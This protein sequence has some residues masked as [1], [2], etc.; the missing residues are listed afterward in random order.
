MARKKEKEDKKGKGFPFRRPPSLEGF[1]KTSQR[2]A[3]G[4]GVSADEKR[5]LT[6]EEFAEKYPSTATLPSDTVGAPLFSILRPGDK[7]FEYKP[8]PPAKIVRDKKLYGQTFEFL[9]TKGVSNVDIRNFMIEFNRGISQNDYSIIVKALNNLQEN[10]DGVNKSDINRLMRMIENYNVT[11][12]ES[13]EE[14]FYGMF[15]PYLRGLKDKVIPDAKG[16]KIQSSNGNIIRFSDSPSKVN[17]KISYINKEVLKKNASNKV[18]EDALDVWQEWATKNYYPLEDVDKVPIKKFASIFFRELQAFMTSESNVSANTIEELGRSLITSPLYSKIV[19]E[20]ERMFPSSGKFDRKLFYKNLFKIFKGDEVYAIQVL[21]SPNYLEALTPQTRDKVMELYSKEV[22]PEG[23]KLPL[24]SWVAGALKSQMGAGVGLGA[25]NVYDEKGKNLV[26]SGV[27]P[28]FKTPFRIPESIERPEVSPSR[29]KVN[30]SLLSPYENSAFAMEFYKENIEPLYIEIGR[31]LQELNKLKETMKPAEKNEM[32]KLDGILRLLDKIRDRQEAGGDKNLELG[33]NKPY[34][35][36]PSDTKDSDLKDLKSMSSGILDKEKTL[37]ENNDLLVE[38]RD[39]ML[40]NFRKYHSERKKNE[41][42]RNNIHE[43]I[44]SKL[45]ELVKNLNITRNDLVISY[46]DRDRIKNI[47]L[48]RIKEG[49][50]KYDIINRVFIELNE[51]AKIVEEEPE[52]L[53]NTSI[54]PGISTE[55]KRQRFRAENEAAR[56]EKMDVGSLNEKQRREV[57]TYL[58]DADPT[59]Y[60]GEE[61]LKL[62]KLIEVLEGVSEEGDEEMLEGLNERNLK[63]IKLAARLRKLYEGLYEDIREEVYPED[64]EE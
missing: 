5:R 14:D 44:E 4:E 64:E 16:I 61:Y 34:K 49:E 18:Y 22:G 26:G 2:E 45:D 59:S 42:E 19:R 12:L 37:A 21:T 46:D 52:L 41:D 3:R 30:Y 25:K 35:D 11:N 58:Q 47:Q 1:P 28:E 24:G 43:T 36:I 9:T 29:K 50:Q 54:S 33:Y 15:V 60:F 56:F 23:M 8:S 13:K 51:D 53:G 48:K 20:S 10:N 57:K 40:S 38:K 55:E 63:V 6:E 62:G 17:P 31:K 32:R 39:N 27:A 7:G